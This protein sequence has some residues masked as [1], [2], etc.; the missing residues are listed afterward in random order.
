MAVLGQVVE[1]GCFKNGKRISNAKYTHNCTSAGGSEVIWKFEVLDEQGG[2]LGHV[3]AGLSCDW[4]GNETQQKAQIRR[5]AESL[6][7]Q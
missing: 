1:Q 5:I 4:Q 2:L 7:P 6:L 3:D